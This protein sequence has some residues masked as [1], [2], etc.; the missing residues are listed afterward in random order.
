MEERLRSLLGLNSYEARAY[1]HLLRWGPQRPRDIARGAGVPYQRIYDVLDSLVSRGLVS[2]AGEGVYAAVEPSRAFHAIAEA[3]VDD[4]RRKA[5]EIRRLGDELERALGQVSR[6]SLSLVHGLAR[7]FAEAMEAVRRCRGPVYIMAYKGLER[8]EEL[9]HY[10]ESLAA[11][12]A[13]AGVSGVRVLAASGLG[14]P[15]WLAR[16]LPEALVEVSFSDAAFL[17]LMVAC[18]TVIIGLPGQAGV[19]AVVVRSTEF[20]E[21]VIERVE[22][23]WRR[24]AGASRA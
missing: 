2:P 8:A 11:E 12:A 10:I 9:R 22:A 23:L 5:E 14:L 13:R 19:V 4:A 1:L 24:G 16:M 18:D 3:V 21:A 17:D 7:V 20:A 6:A 15:P